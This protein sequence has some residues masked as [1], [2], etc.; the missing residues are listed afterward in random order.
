M[1]V[2]VEK[3]QDPVARL[4]YVS[5]SNIYRIVLIPNYKRTY[6]HSDQVEK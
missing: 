6:D 5:I 1:V 3:S 2:G 4:D